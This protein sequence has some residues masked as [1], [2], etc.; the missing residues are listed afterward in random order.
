MLEASL[1]GIPAY[2]N[3]IIIQ[4]NVN[5]ISAPERKIFAFSGDFYGFQLK[6]F[7]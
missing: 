3:C 4:F 7:D 1:Y 5:I 6:E 2:F